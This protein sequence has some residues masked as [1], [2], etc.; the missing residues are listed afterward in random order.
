MTATVVPSLPDR[1]VIDLPGQAGSGKGLP[2]AELCSP[3]TGPDW[4]GSQPAGGWE[5]TP[6]PDCQPSGEDM[7]LILQGLDQGERDSAAQMYAGRKN[8]LE[9]MT[10]VYRLREYRVRILR[11][12]GWTAEAELVEARLMKERSA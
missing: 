5:G 3:L 6:L 1:L 9:H 8:P 12:M 7:L 2:Q 10:T 4:A 11:A